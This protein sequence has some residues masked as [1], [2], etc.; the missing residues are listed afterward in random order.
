MFQ[1][2]F[3]EAPHLTV[4]LLSPPFNCL[5]GYR[6]DSEHISMGYHQV[7]NEISSQIVIFLHRSMGLMPLYYHFCCRGCTSIK[8][9]SAAVFRRLNNISPPVSAGIPLSET[10][11]YETL[12]QPHEVFNSWSPI[13]W[14]PITRSPQAPVHETIAMCG[15]WCWLIW[16]E[17]LSTSLHEDIFNVW[18]FR[19]C[20]CFCIFCWVLWSTKGHEAIAWS[21]SSGASHKSA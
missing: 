1:G 13:G 4:I 19:I 2:A 14:F 6:V 21:T 17:G 16:G 7:F 9:H 3:I 20:I 5:N 8:Y 10:L 15:T 11:Q 12:E 18:C